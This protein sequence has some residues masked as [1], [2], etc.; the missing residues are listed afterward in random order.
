[1]LIEE[2]YFA[3]LT[4]AV[5]ECDRLASKDYERNSVYTKYYFPNVGHCEPDFSHSS[6]KT[7]L[8]FWILI[9]GSIVYIL[10]HYPIF[11]W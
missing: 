3:F 6:I 2:V 1:M 4:V 7:A 9:L 5:C 10:Y 11:R 8:V